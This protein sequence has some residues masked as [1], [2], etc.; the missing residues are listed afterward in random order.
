VTARRGPRA[1]ARALSAT[2]LLAGLAAACGGSSGGSSGPAAPAAPTSTTAVGLASDGSGAC[3]ILYHRDVKCWGLNDFGQLGDGSDKQSDVPVSVSGLTGVLGLVGESSQGGY[4]A[5]LLSG[6]VDCWGTNTSGALGNGSTTL[7]QADVP[8][9]VTGI[10]D[11]TNGGTN[12]AYTY[13]M[14]LGSESVR[15]WGDNTDGQLGNGARAPFSNVPVGV[16]GV[17][18]PVGLASNGTSFCAQLKSGG[19]ECWGSNAGGALGDA[20]TA[21][22]SAVPVAV[23]GLNYIQKLSRSGGGY[24]V[25]IDGGGVKCWGPNTAGSLGDGQASGYSA[26]PVAVKDLS[27]VA[28]LDGTCAVL[29]NGR[30]KCWGSGANGELG[31]GTVGQ[32]SDVAVP[33]KG[34]TGV[35][36]LV[37]NYCA[38]VKNGRVECW[39]SNDNDGALGNGSKEA[40]SDVAVPVKGIAGA[41]S[42]VYDAAGGGGY[43][44]LLG[45][46]G[47]VEC[48]GDNHD[49]ELGDGGKEPSS[50]VPVRVTGLGS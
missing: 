8:V 30:V 37:G 17:F 36:E 49:G 32:Q 48:W 11:A 10:S 19:A 44:A 20:S 9:A 15:C 46:S 39:G 21:A 16:L 45:I 28:S 43:C 38:S 26:V 14:L 18:K 5:V 6:G 23:R 40:F 41:T 4:C 35:S 3:A 1:A 13:C 50:A 33:V 29:G 2:L 34:L 24:C 27:G 25:V 42:L 12:N 7:T 47:R 31:N 22:S